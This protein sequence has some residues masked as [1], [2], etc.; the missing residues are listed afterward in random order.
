VYQDNLF[1]KTERGQIGNPYGMEMTAMNFQTNLQPSPPNSEN[2]MELLDTNDL[3]K[4]HSGYQ[5][6]I[7]DHDDPPPYSHSAAAAAA[8]LNADSDTEMYSNLDHV[9]QGQQYHQ[10]G[11]NPGLHL[12]GSAVDDGYEDIDTDEDAGVLRVPTLPAGGGDISEGEVQEIYVNDMSSSGGEGDVLMSTG[13]EYEP[14]Q[15]GHE[16][17]H[18]VSKRPTT[19]PT[20]L[21]TATSDP[22][23]AVSPIGATSGVKRS[24]EE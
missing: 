5:T 2:E 19:P 14:L 22:V 12:I 24:L 23:S 7:D 13:S 21:T 17:F 8:A 9:G 4:Q 6:V 20:P 3:S 15:H 10:D 16:H 1:F 18:A 11:M